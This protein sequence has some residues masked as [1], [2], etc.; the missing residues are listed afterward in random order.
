MY[1]NY[2]DHDRGQRMFYNNKSED[3][4]KKVEYFQHVLILDQ[5]RLFGVAKSKIFDFDSMNLML[6]FY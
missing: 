1:V 2:K 3:L 5:Q 6:W 4:P